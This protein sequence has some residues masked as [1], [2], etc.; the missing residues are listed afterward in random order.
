MASDT[1]PAVL[2]V[3][4][5]GFIGRHLARYIHDNNLASEVRLVDK[6]LPQLAWLAPEFQEA[7]SKEKFVQADASR[8]QHFP[9][10]FDRA[11]GGQFDYVINCGGETRHSQPDDVYEL[12][13]YA[14][15]VALGREVARR[16]I[17]SFVE[18]S[19]AHVYKPGS[20]VRKEGDK[21]QPW[22]KLAEWKMKASAELEKISG[23]NYTLL[24]LPHVYGEYDPGYF[25]TG[26]CLAR[27]HLDLQ[28][29]LELLYTKDLKINTLYVGD[30]ASAL[31]KA[32]E[33]RANATGSVPIAFNV[34]DH[35]DTR[36]EHVAEALSTVF[37][38]KCTF[39]G[40]LASQF[41]K[42][43]MDDVV[44]DMNEECL[45]VWAE[46]IEQKKIERPGP[47]S[48]FLERDVLKDSDM[49]IDGTLFETTL[50]WKPTR[51]RFD[52]EG[53][54]AIVESYKRMGWWP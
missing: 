36:Q 50:G 3:G 2:I 32:A 8:E 47:I 16:G 51:E 14:L 4:G 29:D 24:R 13:S 43:N 18:C 9:R 35:G 22:H 17:R 44:D 33:W 38:L 53:V 23:L 7:C 6:V 26:I 28:K 49:S 37:G 25:A 11:N 52:A 40:S 21:L 45:Q 41:A 31:W 1:K 54:R 46:L 12:R 5:L 19:T 15:T 34:V 20:S 10:I 39:L 42:M 48:P 27:V 30:A